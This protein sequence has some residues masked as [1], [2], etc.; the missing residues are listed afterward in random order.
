[1]LTK[2]IW[3]VGSSLGLEVLDETDK[4]Y[5]VLWHNGPSFMDGRQSWIPKSAIAGLTKASDSVAVTIY[6]GFIKIWFVETL[7]REYAP[8]EVS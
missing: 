4:A 1:M 7:R 8:Q 6:R 3:I 2:I 5:F